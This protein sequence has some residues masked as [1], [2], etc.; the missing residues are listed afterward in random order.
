MSN[1]IKICTSCWEEE[2]VCDY[3]KY[4]FLDKNIADAIIN[5]NLKG[6]RTQY[7]CEGHIE[8]DD[9]RTESRVL[10]INFTTQFRLDGLPEGFTYSKSKKRKDAHRT[11]LYKYINGTIYARIDKKYIPY[12]LE[13]DK[14]LHLDI[15]KK[16]VDELPVLDKRTNPYCYSEYLQTGRPRQPEYVYEVKGW[17]TY[18]VEIDKADFEKVQQYIFDY[19]GRIEEISDC[20]E[21]LILYYLAKHDMF[22]DD[23]SVYSWWLKSKK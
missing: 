8:P 11:I 20:G 13:E 19:Q 21:V 17:K 12:D 18:R 1:E 10:D 16:W 5:M 9:G 6:Y 2:C 15:L 7:S 3:E 23:M 22:S 4:A 14:K